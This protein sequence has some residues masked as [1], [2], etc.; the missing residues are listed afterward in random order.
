M[1][2]HDTEHVAGGSQ[3]VTSPIC[4]SI[5]TPSATWALAVGQTEARLAEKVEAREVWAPGL[6]DVH[7]WR[8][9]VP[10]RVRFLVGGASKALTLLLLV[11][12]ATAVAQLTDVKGSDAAAVVATLGTAV[13]L[14][15]CGVGWEVNER[16]N[17]RVRLSG[18]AGGL[19]W[20]FDQAQR[21]AQ[22]AAKRGV[23]GAGTLAETIGAMRP[24]VYQL[25]IELTLIGREANNRDVGA[26]GVYYSD[27]RA[28]LRG[29]YDDVQAK[30][31]RVVAEAVTAGRILMATR[32]DLLA[33]IPPVAPVEAVPDAPRT[34]LTEAVQTDLDRA[35]T[36]LA[37]TARD[38]LT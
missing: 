32:E 15:L 5:D 2:E 10:G 8:T 25:L 11:G 31:V 18:T 16:T 23:E 36:R 33:V 14:T 34:A 21:E 12:G 17:S 9:G 7:L 1:D 26:A 19:E 22:E 28:E 3:D 35:R 27:Y 13:L 20:L 38:L 30:L 6:D 24:G 29:R 4:D 37:L